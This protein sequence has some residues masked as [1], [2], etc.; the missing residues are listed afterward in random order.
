M[1]QAISIASAAGSGGLTGPN[2]I[3]DLDIAGVT[4]D[5]RHVVPGDLFA[6]LPGTKTDGRAFIAEAVAR[7]A[8][9]ILAPPGTAWPAGVPAR[10]VIFD[11]EPRQC[12][13]RIAAVLAGP[14]PE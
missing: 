10:P 1:R 3:A 8:V 9:A 4:A 7:G 2:A 6:A 13:A 11:A 5:S 14:Q 12:L